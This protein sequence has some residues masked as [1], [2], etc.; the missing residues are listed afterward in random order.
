MKKYLNN[1]ICDFTPLF[2]IDYTIK[3]NLVSCCFFKRNTGYY[4]DFSRYIIGIEKLY[5]NEKRNALLEEFKV[6]QEVI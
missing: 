1:T 2:N 5:Y 3:K 4:K 6:L